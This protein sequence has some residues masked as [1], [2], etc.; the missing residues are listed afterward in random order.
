MHYLHFFEKGH[1]VVLRSVSGYDF[2]T[3]V[4]IL[5]KLLSD[6]ENLCH[7]A[8]SEVPPEVQIPMIVNYCPR[9]LGQQGSL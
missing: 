6:F 5:S 9:G 4:S 7:P 3:V 8:A 1:H 2:H